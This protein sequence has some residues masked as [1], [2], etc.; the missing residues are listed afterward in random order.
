MPMPLATLFHSREGMVIA[1]EGKPKGVVKGSGRRTPIWEA[2]IEDQ[3]VTSRIMPTPDGPRRASPDT[4]MWMPCG[5]KVDPF[6][7]PGM[8]QF[9]WYVP[10]DE[11]SHSYLVTWGKYVDS[12]DEAERFYE[13]V[14]SYWK[15]MVI[16]TFN[17][18]DVAAREAMERFYAEEDGW[19]RERLFR[20]DLII[21]EW[22]KL[23]STHNR[24]IQRRRPD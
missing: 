9:E 17:S 1:E 18:D 22:R 19:H 8:I 16:D 24:G 21:T 10:V 5:L 23:A 3:K 4:S 13:N 20:P 2:Q 6:P 14:Y 12:D 11:K 7:S 15:H